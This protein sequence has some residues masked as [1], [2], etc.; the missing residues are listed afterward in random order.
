M[1][2]YYIWLVQ[3]MGYASENASILLEHFGDAKA[4]YESEEK[5]FSKIGELS[6][7]ERRAL[8]SKDLGPAE[9]V[10]EKAAKNGHK[11]LHCG[12]PEYPEALCTIYQKPI[13]LYVWGDLSVLSEGLLFGVVGT[14]KMD[15]YGANQAELIGAM[16]ARV[17]ITTVT[18]LA[19]GIDIMAHRG[20]L[21][22]EGSTVGVLGSGLDQ[23]YPKENSR[24]MRETANAGAVITEYEYGERPLPHHFPERNRI[25]AG[26]CRGVAVIQAPA[27]SGALIT[28]RLALDSGRDVFALPGNID[29]PRQEGS[30]AL[31]RDGAKPIWNPYDICE[32]Y[33]NEIRDTIG[34]KEKRQTADPQPEEEGAEELQQEASEDLTGAEK[35]VYD[36]LASE[37]LDAE[38]IMQAA[39]VSYK[40]VAT[41]LT[42][43]E[44]RGLAKALPGGRFLKA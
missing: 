25:I 35:M 22:Q 32:V 36:N 12:M 33:K 21:S 31:L 28:A 26:L 11:I 23:L 24:F 4:I 39:G 38:E 27:A 14:R 3:A 44:M 41:A 1:E 10:V 13:V 19:R 5:A 2:R 29:N 9:R 43:L 37:P 16:L 6:V 8:R 17:G 40:E 15:V 7:R 42:I 34:I 20:A 18:G 30:N